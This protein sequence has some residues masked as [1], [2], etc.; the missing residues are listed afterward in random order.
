M[1]AR[2][3]TMVGLMRFLLCLALGV[4]AIAPRSARACGQTPTPYVTLVD[5]LPTARAHLPRDGA[6]VVRGKLWGPS[7][8][9][10]LFAD[11]RLLDEAGNPIP[12]KS[13]EWYSSQPALALGWSS[14]VPA[15]SKI[16]VEASV[17]AGAEKPVGA[18]GP[19][20]TKYVV[21]VGSELAPPLV[22]AAPL[23]VSL[24]AFDADR[25]KCEGLCG[26][27][28]CAKVGTARALRARITVPAATGGVDF[29][30]YRGWL[31][32]TD[33][34][35]ASF[36]GPGEGTRAAG[37]INLM[38][39]INIRPG[40][41]TEIVQEVFDEERPYA[42]CFALNLWDPAGH[43]VQAEPICLPSI[44]PSEHL[45][46]LD[47]ANDVS[48]GCSA[49]SGRAGGGLG[50]LLIALAA[51]GLRRCNSCRRFC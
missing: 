28:S 42:P 48:V 3:F 46:A 17:P 6:V 5:G 38:H 30:G 26:G 32:F 7:G 35:P 1:T 43:A 18:E 19:Q 45:R 47:G 9:P 44:L 29:D 4:G 31:R 37:N 39:W 25:F 51:V 34:H 50:L 27:G 12:A 22:L 16:T 41:A 40:V 33:D 13:V 24:E 14:P 15:G 10:F 36:A 21:E 2:P 49:V 23:R 20:T 11:V 8:G